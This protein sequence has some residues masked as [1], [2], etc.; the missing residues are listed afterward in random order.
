MSK[1]QS[2]TALGSLGAASPHLLSPAEG[3]VPL[4]TLEMV[5]Q[6]LL[7]CRIVVT[8]PDP[9][10]CSWGGTGQLFWRAARPLLCLAIY[11]QERSFR[12]LEK[13]TKWLHLMGKPKWWMVATWNT[14]LQ[15]G[16]MMEEGS[17]PWEKEGQGPLPA[18]RL[19]PYLDRIGSPF[20]SFHVSFPKRMY[21][22]RT[23]ISKFLLCT[24]TMVNVWLI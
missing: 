8:S 20:P 1:C 3:C 22:N 9:E 15:T 4:P 12:L 2:W 24:D 21:F 17:Q 13:W 6:D 5:K 14:V 16:S 18:T 7:L 23:D 10:L 11:P 19:I